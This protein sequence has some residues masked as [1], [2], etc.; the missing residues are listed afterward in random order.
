MKTWECLEENKISLRTPTIIQEYHPKCILFLNKIHC[1]ILNA[2]GG[3]VII[4]N[5]PES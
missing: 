5:V 1:G 2:G 3:L 4:K